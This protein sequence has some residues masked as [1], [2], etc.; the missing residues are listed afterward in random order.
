MKTA[1][2][3]IHWIALKNDTS[4]ILQFL[5]SEIFMLFENQRFIIDIEDHKTFLCRYF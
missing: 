3:N 2:D 1:G 5:G 4:M